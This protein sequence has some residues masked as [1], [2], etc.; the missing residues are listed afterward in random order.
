MP[1]STRAFTSRLPASPRSARGVATESTTVISPARPPFGQSARRPSE[2]RMISS[3]VL[4]SHGPDHRAP[5][6]AKP[7]TA[8]FS[9]RPAAAA[10]DYEN[11]HVRGPSAAR[12]LSKETRAPRVLTAARPLEAESSPT[13][14][15]LPA[16]GR[17]H[18]RRASRQCQA[19][20]TRYKPPPH[21]PVSG[22][23]DQRHAGFAGPQQDPSPRPESPST[24][25]GTRFASFLR[26]G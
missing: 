11:T 13:A 1:S 9:G 25:E 10:G 17:R 18:R 12:V 16:S 23:A 7:S 14:D 5:R 22:I 21:Q 15:G 20:R 26:T 24:S 8:V 6:G 19:Q 2:P 3:C 4:V